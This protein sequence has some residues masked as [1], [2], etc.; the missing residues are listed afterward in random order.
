MLYRKTYQFSS[1]AGMTHMESQLSTHNRD[2][3]SRILV[4]LGTVLV[5][6]TIIFPIILSVILAVQERVFLFDFLMPAELFP[7]AVGGGALLFWGALRAGSRRRLIGWSLGAGVVLLF[8]SQLIAILTGL[9]SG[10]AQAGS[11]W[12]V[13][14]LITLSG[15][16][17]AVISLCAGGIMLLLDIFRPQKEPPEGRIAEE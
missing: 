7:F 14:V 1:P 2:L 9:A 16:I 15:Y 4:I 8:G 3:F 12:R 17:L 6:F 13:I 10:E 5:W 11:V